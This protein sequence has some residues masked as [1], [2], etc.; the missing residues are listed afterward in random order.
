ME[1]NREYIDDKNSLCRSVAVVALTRAE[2]S[3]GF[4]RNNLLNPRMWS[5][6]HCRLNVRVRMDS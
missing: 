4:E 5:I 1:N 6:I 3:C 2:R